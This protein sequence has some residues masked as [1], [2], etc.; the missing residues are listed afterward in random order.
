MR[1]TVSRSTQAPIARATGAHASSNSAASACASAR[2]AV[3]AACVPR[4]PARGGSGDRTS[5]RALTSRVQGRRCSRPGTR[6]RLRRPA[7]PP[8]GPEKTLGRRARPCQ[9]LCHGLV[10]GRTGVGLLESFLG[11]GTPSGVEGPGLTHRAGP[12]ADVS[13]QVQCL[14]QQRRPR[15]HRLDGG[16]GGVLPTRRSPR[17][18][19]PR[20]PALAVSGGSSAATPAVARSGGA[21]RWWCRGW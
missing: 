18:V 7:L 6:A 9:P 11:R 17:A 14:T 8:P 1:A 15:R 3:P 10:L 4:W 21:G 2:N 13:V 19:R 16:A 20:R 12:V 5:W